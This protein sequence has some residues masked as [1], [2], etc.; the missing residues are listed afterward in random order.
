MKLRLLLLLSITIFIGCKK[1]STLSFSL[2][3]FSE[4][5]LKI[6]EN[7]SC[8][9]ITIDYIKVVG[10]E[11]IASKINSQ[12]ESYIIKSLFLGEDERPSAK[13]IEEAARQ[14]II[15][16]RDHKNEFEYNLKYE[17]EVTVSKMYENENILCLQLQSYL[18]TGGAHGYGSTHFKNI[19]EE[20]GEE[21]TVSELFED[22]K[23]FLE[24]TE[25]AFRK[26]Y[27]IPE[28]ESIN[29]TGFWF[30]DDTFYLPETI[31]IS[32]KNIVFIYNPYDIASYAEGPI[33]FEIPLKEA[34]PFLS[35]TYFP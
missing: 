12:I 34:K 3:S 31:G 27:K 29:Y 13:S 16:Y 4:S 2:E 1:T 32:K 28:N 30:E 9:K 33:I 21:I 26:K 5:D 19:D 14:F 8:S 18:F 11:A 22:E 25:K 24:L 6:C 23:G 35:N 20:T 7:D 15:A 17:A 10:D